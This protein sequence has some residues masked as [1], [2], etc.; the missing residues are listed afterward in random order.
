MSKVRYLGRLARSLDPQ[1]KND[2]AYECEAVGAHRFS[3]PDEP[4]DRSEEQRAWW[5]ALSHGRCP[6]CAVER[7]GP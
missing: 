2:V 6:L 5:Q 4:A 1:Q 7:E 3:L